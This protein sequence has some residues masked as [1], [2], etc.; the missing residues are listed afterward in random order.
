M[1]KTVIAKG[2]VNNS[3]INIYGEIHSDIPDNS[4]YSN[5]KLDDH[6]LLVEHTSLRCDI[7]PEETALFENAKGSEWVFREYHTKGNLMCVDTRVENGFLNGYEE[8]ELN[9]L[10]IKDFLQKITKVVKVAVANKEMYSVI[11]DL[12]SEFI[13][14]IQKQVLIFTY[15]L[16]T[17]KEIIIHSQVIEKDILLL[18]IKDLL[19]KNVI[20]L[21]GIYMDLYITNIVYSNKSSKSISIFV[22]MNHAVRLSRILKLKIKNDIKGFPIDPSWEPLGDP[23]I[24]SD[25]LSQLR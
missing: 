17:K 2:K 25:I 16:N 3:K 15:L 23:E 21:A 12:F 19:I 18:N 7:R 20:K 10:P 9:N 8:N 24:E 22:G 14:F 6:L 11:D 5:L 1:N 13:T 4:F